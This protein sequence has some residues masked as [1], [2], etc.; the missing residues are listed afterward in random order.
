M[1]QEDLRKGKSGGCFDEGRIGQVRK[2]FQ[3][4]GAAF[5]QENV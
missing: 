3:E 2:T 4:E 5:R 1:N